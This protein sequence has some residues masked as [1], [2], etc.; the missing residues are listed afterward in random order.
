MIDT[1]IQGNLPDFRE[2]DKDAT[3]ACRRIGGHQP[4]GDDLE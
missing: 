2:S 1:G 4:R 3:L